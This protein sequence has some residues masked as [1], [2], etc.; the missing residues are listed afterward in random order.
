MRSVNT[1]HEG[2]D[3]HIQGEDFFDTKNFPYA[4]F[5]SS[6]MV[7]ENDVPASVFGTLTIKGVSNPVTFDIT[8]FVEK[9]HPMSKVPA[10]GANATATILR[11]DFNAGK[12]APAVSD[13]VTLELSIEALAK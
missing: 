13:E 12:Y 6:G 11:S 1:G 5:K 4:T 8:H 10:M 9:A 3:Q 7:Y 2:F